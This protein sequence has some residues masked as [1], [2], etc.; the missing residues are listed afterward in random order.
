MISLGLGALWGYLRTKNSRWIILTCLMVIQLIIFHS[1]NYNI[2]FHSKQTFTGPIRCISSIKQNPTSWSITGQDPR[3]KEKFILSFKEPP[4]IKPGDLVQIQ[5]QFRHIDPPTNPGQFNLKSYYNS[6]QLSGILNVSTYNV[7]PDSKKTYPLRSLSNIITLRITAL[8]TRFLPQSETNLLFA[9]LFGDQ[10]ISLDPQVKQQ[11]KQLGLSHLLVVSG[12][13]IS[14][15][16]GLSFLLLNKFI[17]NRPMLFGILSLEC[18]VFYLITGGGPS[19]LRA[20][21]MNTV[22]LLGKLSRRLLYFP[23]V[24]GFSLFIMV[25]WTPTM[26]YNL[27]FWLSFL[28]TVSLIYGVP[29]LET[30]VPS[31]WP[32]S[33]K[34]ILATSISPFL[35]TFPI[36]LMASH[37]FSPFSIAT[38]IVA[39][40]VIEIL[41]IVG[42]IGT[43]IGLIFPLLAIIP[44]NFCYAIII[45]MNKITNF[46][47]PH[48]HSFMMPSPHIVLVVLYYGLLARSI[49]MA[50]KPIPP[51]STP[52]QYTLKG[53]LL[54]HAYLVLCALYLAVPWIPSRYL[55]VTMLDVGQGDCILIHTP[56]NITCLIDT[57]PVKYGT[58]YTKDQVDTVIIPALHAANI[59]SIDYVFISHFDMDHAGGLASLINA[60]KVK[61]IVTNGNIQKIKELLPSNISPTLFQITAGDTLKL[62]P[63]TQITCLYPVEFN[64][65]VERRNHNS[66]VLKLEHNAIQFLFTGDIEQEDE[67]SLLSINHSQLN[68]TVVQAPHHG[69]KTSSTPPFIQA[70]SP[71]IALISCGRHNT[72]RH[73]HPDTLIHYKEAGIPTLRTDT[74]GALQFLS[75]GKKLFYKTW[76]KS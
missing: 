66:L 70:V 49:Q 28:A 15:L 75:N 35:F 56:F 46:I 10:T 27:G 39:V 32:D 36:L 20:I 23:H 50:S 67:A 30:K 62:D 53:F 38:N 55:H 58:S 71:A 40:P 5:G 25:F 4:Q 18:V 22:V 29:F 63:V 21:L 44:L 57:G 14:L 11:Y 2:P 51:S 54:K 61:H 33:I 48:F 76:I 12:S 13:Q 74:Q 31:H 34:T 9:L 69:S 37:D 43:V 41:V 60:I 59:T 3:T 17:K 47:A 8:Y 26:M 42:F 64:P 1:L 19:I 45:G 68:A 6:K 72:Y 65:Q 24:I 7:I 16:I 73:P 52:K